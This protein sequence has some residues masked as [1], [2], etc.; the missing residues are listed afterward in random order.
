MTAFNLS[1]IMD[2]IATTLVS[3]NVTTKAFGYPIP[4]PPAPCAVVLYPKKI[5]FDMTMKRGA[6]EA[7]FEVAFFVGR[8][9]DLK[10]RDALSDVID[11]ATGIKE[12]L[13]AEGT[14]LSEA[15]SSCRVTDCKIEEILVGEVPYLAA[16]FTLDVIT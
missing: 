13:E 11:G 4:N 9:N 2:A 12:A 3:A 10:A 8:A 1:G 5:D 14:D 16:V 7:T 6:D 15:I